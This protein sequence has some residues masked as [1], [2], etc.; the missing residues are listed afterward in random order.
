MQIDLVPGLPPSGGYENIVI[1]MD[2]LSRYLFA[3]PT[4]NQDATT[5]AKSEN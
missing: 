2:V 4:S 5:I 3:Y 1:A